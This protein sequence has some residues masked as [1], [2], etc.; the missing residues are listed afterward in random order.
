MLKRELL[1]QDVKNKLKQYGIE[2]HDYRL[3]MQKY[4]SEDKAGVPYRALIIKKSLPDEKQ[5]ELEMALKDID[6]S[7]CVI[8][9]NPSHGRILHLK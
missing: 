7:L 2:E 9:K 4:H 3:K 8:F 6:S 5:F 1:N